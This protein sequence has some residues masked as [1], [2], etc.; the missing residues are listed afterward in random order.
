M[1]KAAVMVEVV[2]QGA[3]VY[4]EGGVVVGRFEAAEKVPQCRCVFAEYEYIAIADIVGAIGDKLGVVAEIYPL[5][6]SKE[7]IAGKH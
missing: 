6:Q 7:A 2:H 1:Y 5:R 3:E 4:C